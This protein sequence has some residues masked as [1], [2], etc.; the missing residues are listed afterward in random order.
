MSNL[1]RVSPKENK[2]SKINPSLDG[3]N[4]HEMDYFIA[5]LEN[6]IDTTKSA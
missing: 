6:D 1:N 4:K 3:K 2:N 5:H